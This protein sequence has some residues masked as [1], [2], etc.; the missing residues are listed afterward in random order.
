M[1]VI[2]HL[3]EPPNTASWFKNLFNNYFLD[4][5]TPAGLVGSIAGSLLGSLS[6]QNTT[7]SPDE[8]IG[9]SEDG[10]TVCGGSTWYINTTQRSHS[11]QSCV[12][13]TSQTHTATFET[14]LED[15]TL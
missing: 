14:L 13:Q 4:H 10:F 12:S 2:L 6:R 9:T 5:D 8:S 15:N 3:P 1:R 11:V 7:T